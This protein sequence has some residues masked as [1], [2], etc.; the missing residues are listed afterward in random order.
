MPIPR[1]SVDAAALVDTAMR[2]IKEFYEA[3]IRLAK[4]EVMLMELSPRTLTTGRCPQ[5]WHE[6]R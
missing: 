2:G 6:Q 3:G 1:P 5:S 4:A